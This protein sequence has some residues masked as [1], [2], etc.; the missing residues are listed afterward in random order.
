MP[1]SAILITG[2]SSGLGA[3]L[4]KLYGEQGKRLV[5]VGRRDGAELDPAIFGPD[6]YCQAD[7]TQPDAVRTVTA[8]LDA[9]GIDQLDL[10][11]HN[12]GMG[13]YGD[14][15]DQSAA[16]IQAL[17]A[18]NLRAPIALTHALLPRLDAARGKLVFVSSVAST[19]AAPDYAVYTATKAAL[20]GFARSLRIE[21]AGRV[22][23]QVIHPGAVNTGMHAKIGI[24]KSQMDWDKFP[25]AQKAAAQM[26]RAIAGNRRNPAL[27]LGNQAARW[28]G[29][30]AAPLLDRIM[31][32]KTT[33]SYQ[34]FQ[35]SKSSSPPR[36][37]LITGAADGIGK[38]L[39]VRFA[40]AGYAVTG[41]DVDRERAAATQAEIDASG[42]QIRFLFADLTQADEVQRVIS[43]LATGPA[44]DICIHNAGI[45]AVGPFA[46]SDMARQQAVIDLNFQAPLLL[47]AGLLAAEKV[48]TGGS[49]I[50]MSSLSKYASYPGAAVYA[51][52]KDGL[53]S[54]ARSLK[55]GLAGR[56][57]NVLTVF[58][59]PTRTAH[60][61]RYSPDNSRENRRMAPA[62]LADH[63]FQATAARK[64]ILIPGPANRISATLGL[65]A[66]RTI[67]AIMRRTIL[68]KL[69]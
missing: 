64:A 23:V 35:S 18:L 24:P 61:R 60:A 25:S 7:L 69:K 63:I 67:E 16:N 20:D 21:Q 32:K 33:Q 38:A 9:Q 28:A 34:S 19:L 55:V 57:I 50:F 65:L 40:Q 47:N 68:E 46:A 41:I 15:A 29:L 51:A 62:A 12:A 17:I 37:C 48:N 26:V 45:S 8:W 6:H 52:S 56:K 66:P 1:S 49:L 2:G 39:A 14:V 27:G 42:G 59:G 53:A 4:A 10:V 31:R 30:Y 13:Y 54:Y 58:P 22:Q 43:D 44:F 11:I 36:H 5:L 3:A